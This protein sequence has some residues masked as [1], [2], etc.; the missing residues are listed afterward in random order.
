MASIYKT[1]SFTLLEVIISIT[2]LIVGI[3]SAY[4]LLTRTISESRVVSFQF[5]AAYLAQEGIEIVRNIRD[6]NHL[7][8]DP[9]L[10]DLPPA[11]TL[12][13]TFDYR[14][15]SIPDNANCTGNNYLALVSGRYQCSGS[16]YFQRSI[17][18]R[19]RTDEFTNPYME[20]EITI[21]WQEKGT[22]KTFIVKENIYDWLNITP[23]FSG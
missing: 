4:V 14:S 23:P 12:I 7:N 18:L 8:D 21:Y 22:T 11:D 15:Q 9:Y 1:K 16:G 10:Q 19:P 17:I 13:Y 3:L 20:A 2:I 5:T 6:G